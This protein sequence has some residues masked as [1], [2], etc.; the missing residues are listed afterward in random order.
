MEIVNINPGHLEQAI[1]AL[2]KWVIEEMERS[3]SLKE[4]SIVIK[5][6]Q[7]LEELPDREE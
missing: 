3:E 2:R 7:Q 6:I 4:V 5:I 1:L